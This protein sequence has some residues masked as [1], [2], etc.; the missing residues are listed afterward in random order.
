[1][2]SQLREST[3]RQ[4]LHCANPEVHYQGVRTGER[5][6]FDSVIG[7]AAALLGAF[8][9]RHL[10]LGVS[11]LSRRSGLPKSTTAR[12]AAE[13]TT[14][15]FLE[16]SEE[17]SDLKL[18][19][20]LFELGELA[21]RQRQLREVALPYM[22][23]LRQV[24]KQ[25]VH[26]AVLVG[27]DVMYV[28]IVRSRNAPR[29]PSEVGGRLPAHA[30]GVGKALLAFAPE[31]VVQAVIDRGLPAVGP[32][33][34]TAPGLLLRELRRIREAGIAY[35]S[36]ESGHGVGCA[37]S[38]ILG[39]DGRGVAAMSISGWNG[40]LDLR[41]VGPAV[42]TAARALSRDLQQRGPAVAPNWAVP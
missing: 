7:R 35:E 15:G 10:E 29:M 8:D 17:G 31:S 32:R 9:A 26:L 38:P 39:P 30:A 22:A 2:K 1:M 11:E 18:G 33:T 12:L 5:N 6:T 16:K 23:D 14:Y 20:K 34:I 4:L 40:T 28:E 19:T 21:S 3:L 42:K 13:L 25:T 27:T 41:R 36:E 24:S 37:A